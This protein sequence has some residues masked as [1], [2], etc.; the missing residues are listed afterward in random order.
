MKAAIGSPLHENRSHRAQRRGDAERKKRG[1]VSLHA[2]L[3]PTAL[4]AG[5]V[6]CG[7]GTMGIPGDRGIYRQVFVQNF[8]SG[9]FRRMPISSPVLFPRRGLLLLL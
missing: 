2:L 6:G 5:T 1:K 4:L 8:T 9:L 3:R 7:A